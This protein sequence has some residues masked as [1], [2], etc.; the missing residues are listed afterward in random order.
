LSDLLHDDVDEFLWFERATPEGLAVRQIMGTLA[1]RASEDQDAAETLYAIA[2]QAAFE[3]LNLY[4]R[5]RHLFDRIAPRRKLLPSLI[6]IHPLTSKV[7]ASM[8]A[9]SKLGSQTDDS[10]R[11]R[12]R[13]WFTSDAPA[14]VYA[15][16]I[17][18]SVCLNT[19]LEPVATQQKQWESFD[20]QHHQRTIVRPLPNYVAG[21]KDIPIPIAPQSVLQYWR[22]GKEIILEEMSDFHKRPEWADYRHKRAYQNG[23]KPG[24]IQHAIFK[25]IL[26]ALRT[27]AGANKK[28]PAKPN[29]PAH[30]ENTTN[31]S[32]RKPQ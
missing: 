7:V 15:R 6:S 14:N 9:D 13:S 22:K 8:H 4:I 21:L 2:T 16:A 31:V 32:P 27:I 1:R 18:A 20:R 28:S 29:P 26:A 24:A 30:R 3:V 23:A 19:N 12:S 25:D 11:V 17:I 5:H 10:R